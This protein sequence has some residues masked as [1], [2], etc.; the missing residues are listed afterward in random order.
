MP[1]KLTAKNIERITPMTIPSGYS[2]EEFEYRGR[3][4]DAQDDYNIC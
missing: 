4:A 2:I 1:K 3:P